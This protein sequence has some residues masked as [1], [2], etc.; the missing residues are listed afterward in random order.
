MRQTSRVE[1]IVIDEVCSG[2]FCDFCGEKARHTGSIN[3]P[4]DWDVSYNLT[5]CCWMHDMRD[6][7]EYEEKEIV[8][9][10]ACFGKLY[11]FAKAGGILQAP[12]KHLQIVDT[13]VE[14]LK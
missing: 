9:C 3:G 13:K 8:I 7:P 10:P 12:R 11:D 5:T 2:I 4:V 14:R 1:K 6:E